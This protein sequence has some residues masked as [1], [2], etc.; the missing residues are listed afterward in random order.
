[1]KSFQLALFAILLSGLVSACNRPEPASPE[2]AVAPPAAEPAV[3]P[4]PD[5]PAATDGTDDL[6]H[7][8][9]D[10]VG[11]APAP[12]ATSHSGCNAIMTLSRRA[13]L[14]CSP[15]ARASSQRRYAS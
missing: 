9:G 13:M 10:K 3:T 14:P 1:M 6:P 7:S 8:G 4:E 2:A 11:T 15:S 12:G 5:T